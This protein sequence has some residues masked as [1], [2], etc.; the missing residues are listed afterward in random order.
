MGMAALLAA[1]VGAWH[2][3]SAQRLSVTSASVERLRSEL[4]AAVSGHDPSAA[5][6]FTQ[7]LPPDRSIDP[8]ISQFQHS[9]SQL[10]VTF[11]S[12]TAS[13]RDATVQTLG[14]TELSIT[15][16]GS[17]TALKSVLS[18]SMDRFPGIVLQH[19]TLHRLAS[20]NELE[21]RV[22]LVQLSRPLAPA[23]SGAGS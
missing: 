10:G 23:A 17:Y 16:R 8:V 6:D 22:D 20:P 18:E 3:Q 15:L 14:R 4:R 1:I 7:H 5:I 12:V 9:S 11:V 13:P 2:W 19:L 21:A